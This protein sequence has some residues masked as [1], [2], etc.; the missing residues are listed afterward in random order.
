MLFQKGKAVSPQDEE[1]SC[2]AKESEN[3]KKDAKDI[4]K[5]L[6][7]THTD[8]KLADEHQFSKTPTPQNQIKKKHFPSKTKTNDDK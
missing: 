5:M 2:S 6:K 3:E 4:A 8:G 7:K 1:Q